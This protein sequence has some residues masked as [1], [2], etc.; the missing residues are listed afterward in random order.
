MRT[1]R[2][3]IRGQARARS[4]KVSWSAMIVVGSAANAKRAL[5]IREEARCAASRY[6]E[7]LRSHAAADLDDIE[8]TI[9][10][11][12]DHALADRTLT[13]R[14]DEL[15]HEPE[16]VYEH[17]VGVCVLSLILGIE[18]GYSFGDLKAL[19]AGAIL[20]DVGKAYVSD[21]IW[22]LPRKLTDEEF[23]EVRKHPAL[24]FE[25][26]RR[27][28][29]LDI[30]AAQVVYQHHERMDGKGYPRG[31]VGEQ[32]HRFARIVAVADVYDAV[33]STRPYRDALPIEEAIRIIT[34]ERGKAFD[35]IVVE[36]FQR[37]FG[38]AHRD[39]VN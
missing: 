7:R 22:N 26:L 2:T 6:I 10:R 33:T 35:P 24:G 34:A 28:H 9:L 14:F 21:T 19:A 36:A 37:R 17:S 23:E 38:K 29:G 25:A 4:R 15:R 1:L 12:L 31:L 16:H 5:A 18:L 27:H 13:T 32:I 30:R 11:A 39:N 20:H 8:S 3:L